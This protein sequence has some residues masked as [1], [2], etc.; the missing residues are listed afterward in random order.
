M[1][2][3]R[4]IS[5]T[6]VYLLHLSKIQPHLCVFFEGTPGIR[7]PGNNAKST[8]ARTVAGEADDGVL[9]P[10]ERPDEG[11]VFGVP[12]VDPAILPWRGETG[13]EAT[14]CGWVIPQEIHQR[15]RARQKKP[16]V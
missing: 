4:E 7:N 13:D 11:G 2:I 16:Y 14:A 8:T 10:R 15:W 6:R 9:V 5:H 1:R 3:L 12:L